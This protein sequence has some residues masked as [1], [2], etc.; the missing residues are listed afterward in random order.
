[1]W[2]GSVKSEWGVSSEGFQEEDPVYRALKASRFSSNKAWPYLK[3]NTPPFNQILFFSPIL[4]VVSITY[5]LLT[6]LYFFG[7]K[8]IFYRNTPFD[9]NY[10]ETNFEFFEKISNK[11]WPYLKV[12]T[13]YFNQ[14]LFFSP[15]LFAVLIHIHTVN[16]CVFFWSQMD[17]LSWQTINTNNYVSH[18]L[19]HF[20]RQNNFRNTWCFQC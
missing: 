9:T 1:M 2:W 19:N 7:V 8:W 5:T 15:I 10:R 14:I 20:L 6:I 17:I 11:A 4:F 13:K 16:N 18:Y 12:D 3:I